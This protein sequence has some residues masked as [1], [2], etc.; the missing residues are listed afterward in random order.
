MNEIPLKNFCNSAN[1]PI[2]SLTGNNQIEQN[3]V[4]LNLD[5]NNVVESFSQINDAFCNLL[6]ANGLVCAA[7]GLSECMCV[8]LDT[9]QSSANFAMS[10]PNPWSDMQPCDNQVQALHTNQHLKCFT[11]K[12]ESH[13]LLTKSPDTN[14]PV[15]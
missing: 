1:Q 12:V 8:C 10:M 5:G 2:S 7:C 14:Y 13:A 6:N 15:Y 3:S 9:S 11:G 4:V